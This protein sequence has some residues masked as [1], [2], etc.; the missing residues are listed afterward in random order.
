MA[1]SPYVNGTSAGS[2]NIVRA[3]DGDTLEYQISPEAYVNVGACSVSV[4]VT[5]T[6]ILVSVGG[7]RPIEDSD[8]VECLIGQHQTATIS[9]GSFTINDWSWSVSGGKPF[10][11]VIWGDE[12]G[13]SRYRRDQ[14]LQFRQSDLA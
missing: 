11:A 5:V 13:K 6:D 10:R 2:R 9:A 7:T 8:E 12:N 4:S 1:N 3:T 14:Q